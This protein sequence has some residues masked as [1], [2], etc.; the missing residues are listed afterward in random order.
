MKTFLLIALLNGNAFVL[1][2]GLTGAECMQAIE[3]G[4]ATIQVDETRTVPATG[5]KLACEAEQAE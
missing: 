4:V 1:D 5:A 3:S 2:S